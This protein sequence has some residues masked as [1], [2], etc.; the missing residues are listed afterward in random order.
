MRIVNNLFAIFLQGISYLFFT[1]FINVDISSGENIERE[2]KIAVVAPVTGDYGFYG[3]EIVRGAQLA[4]NKL[5]ASD[6]NLKIKLLVEDACL[7]ADTIKSAHK[8][9]NIEKI[10]AIVG[11]YCVIGMVPM[12]ALTEKKQIIAFHTSAV[13][14]PILNAGE[15]TFTTN[16]AIKDEAQKLAEYAYNKLGARKV[17]ILWLLTQWGDDY[18]K[19]FSERF[20]EL[21]GTINN[22]GGVVKEFV[23]KKVNNNNFIIE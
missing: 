3:N 14:D 5:T 7:P 1:V 16:V 13:A 9:L 23:V 20:K 11:S 19:Y 10:D 18:Q 6:S 12:A 8:L 17:S 4:I 22:E 15:Y 21:G 2:I